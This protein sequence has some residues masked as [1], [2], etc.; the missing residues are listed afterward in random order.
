MAI[1]KQ[2]LL[3]IGLGAILIAAAGR[4]APQSWPYLQSAGL[5][6]PLQSLGVAPVTD[7]ASK[8]EKKAADSS[9]GGRGGKGGGPIAVIAVAPVPAIINDKLTAIGTGQALRSVAIRPEVSGRLIGLHVSAGDFV[10]PQ[11]VIANL[12]REATEIALDRARL[13]VDDA[14]TKLTRLEQLQKSGAATNLQMKDANLALQNALLGQRQAEFDLSRRAIIAPI[15]GYVGL[16][17]AEVG[18]QVT[19]STELLW[20]EDRSSLLV[21]FRVPERLVSQIE[22]GSDVQLRPL[23]HPNE[24]I[25]GTITAIDNRVD[26]A[27]RTLRVQ[28]M[29]GNGQDRL[30][31][32][33]AFEIMLSFSGETAPSVDPL[34]IQWGSSGS[35][36]WVVRDGKAARVSVQIL[37]RNAEAVLIR[38]EFQDGDLVVTEGVQNLR[39]GS[40]VA[41]KD[42]LGKASEAAAPSAPNERPKS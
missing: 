11:T 12:D 22:I 16:I 20:L 2:I 33:M 3:I 34:A 13:L 27:S 36:V 24:T 19:A 1:W 26:E 7:D 40:D 31:S 41:P 14:Q 39:P 30:R 10:A 15:G 35:Y 29:L 25:A 4:F 38:A 32:G 18:D 21:E 37:Q 6:A 8:S 23:A 5:L 9:R 28:A 17:G 42:P